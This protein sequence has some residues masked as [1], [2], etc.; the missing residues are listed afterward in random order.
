MV[1]SFLIT[2]F[3]GP[4]FTI[5]TSDTEVIAIGMKMVQIISPLYWVYGFIEIYSGSLR[6]QGSVL[7]TTFLTIT[8]VCLLRIVWVMVIVP[9][10]SLGELVA[11]YPITWTVTA[12]AMICYYIYKQKRIMETHN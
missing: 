3:G 5:F 9:Q 2:V 8:G 11:C 7:V 1:L 10:G 6:A 4:L 12:V